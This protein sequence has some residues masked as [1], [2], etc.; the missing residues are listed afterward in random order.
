M[1]K[2]ITITADDFVA[3]V[4]RKTAEAVAAE[5]PGLSAD[6]IVLPDAI[7]AVPQEDGSV[8]VT[9]P[10]FSVD[11]NKGEGETVPADAPAPKAKRGRKPKDPN[12]PAKPRKAK[13]GKVYDANAKGRPPA[14]FVALSDK[15]KDAYRKM[16][17]ERRKG[18]MVK[19]GAMAK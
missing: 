18:F 5:M 10:G 12:A 7:E 3:F 14:W 17:A 4:S 15:D 6:A 13:A 1:P 11:F 9:V 16:N 19:I 8:V 2:V